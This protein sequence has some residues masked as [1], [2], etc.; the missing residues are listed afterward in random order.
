ML[1]LEKIKNLEDK[2]ASFWQNYHG[3]EPIALYGAGNSGHHVI[4]YLRSK[5]ISPVAIIDS[6]S[7][8]W[9]QEYHGYRVCCI[10]QALTEYPNLHIFISASTFEREIRETINKIMPEDR[11]HFFEYERLFYCEIPEY[12]DF[13]S[14]HM[15]DLSF[16]YE[17]LSDQRSQQ[18]MEEILNLWCSADPKYLE[19]IYTPD[20]YFPSDIIQLS[21]HES[22]VDCGAFTGD[23]F[24]QF[25]ARVCGKYDHYYGLEPQKECH[26]ALKHACGTDERN[27]IFTCG[28]SDR[29]EQLRFS[30]DFDQG[31]AAVTNEGG[32]VIDVCPIDALISDKSKV[33]FI[34]MDIEG[35]ELKALHGAEK[36]IRN[37]M[38]KLAICVYHTME[39]MVEIPEYIMGLGLDYRYYLRH[40]QRFAG[41]ETVFYAV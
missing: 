14:E 21:E 18:T 10:E 9:N 17:N 3:E 12:R 7:E 27:C 30:N 24:E 13:V 23:T 31:H 25:Y 34:K 33:T 16:V 41:V 5:G 22:F 40:H 2:T 28:A 20:Q 15:Q 4:K 37:N 36:T 32:T 1:T 35:S 39:D 19:K 29:K 11:I 8:K 26:A 38:P 6:N